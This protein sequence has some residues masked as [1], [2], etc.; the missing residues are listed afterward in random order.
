MSWRRVEE[1]KPL[2]MLTLEFILSAFKQEVMVTKTAVT[3]VVIDSRL[4]E[5]GSLFVAFRGEQVDGHDYVAAAFAGGAIAALVEH[6]IDGFAILDTRQ[7]NATAISLPICLLVDNT[8]TALQTIAKAWRAQFAT[9]I[10]GVTGSVGKTSTKE[11]IHTLLAQKYTCLKSSGNRNNEIGL[12]LTLLNLRPEHEFAVLEM[13]MYARGEIA[14]LCQL[15]PPEIGVV[16]MINPVHLERL[17]SM[18]AIV[19]AKQE[20]VE[21]LPAHGWAVLNRD[22]ERVMGMAEHTAAQIFTCGSDSRADLWAEGIEPLGLAGSRFTLRTAT[23]AHSV[24]LPLLGAHHVQT[25]VKAAAVARLAGLSWDEIREGLAQAV[26]N[27]R[28]VIKPGLNDTTI[29]DDCYNASPASTM[30][31]LDLL[32]Q[33]NGRRVAVLGDMLE[34]GHVEEEAH[35]QVGRHVVG[36]ADYLVAV[37]RRGRWFGEAALAAGMPADCVW[38]EA[39][40]TAVMS[41][42]AQRLQP[43]DYVLVKGSLGM[44]MDRL[45]AAI[46]RNE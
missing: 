38:I 5:P 7:P 43:H 44:R 14:L 12:P 39:E 45:V 32:Q 22:D 24:T 42:L 25:A 18:E 37:G 33:M 26:N 20:L 41:A 27:T 17:G 36:C 13:G 21:A 4:A 11:L 9:R 3:S 16:T 2:K 10:V 6:P 34:L 8:E 28:L 1:A 35:R 15:A 23:E 46:R 31:A 19:Q 40:V 30:A 29:I